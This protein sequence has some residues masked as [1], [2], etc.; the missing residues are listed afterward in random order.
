MISLLKGDQ[1]LLKNWRPVALLCTDYKLL[2]MVLA[3]RRKVFIEVF[4]GLDQSYC[5]PDRS[6]LDNLFLMRVVFN[7]CK[8]YNLK[9]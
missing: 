1:T 3:N 7:L 6:I 5:V 2:S 9:N 8:Q 4:I